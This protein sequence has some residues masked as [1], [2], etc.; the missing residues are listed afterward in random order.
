[1]SS[2]ISGSMQTMYNSVSTWM[3]RMASNI[4]QQAKRIQSA[5]NSVNTA[6]GSIQ[7]R[8]VTV[9]AHAKGGQIEDGL[10]MANSGEIIGEFSN[11]KNYV[12]NNEM[13]VEGIEQGVF[14]AV[15]NAIMNNP[16]QG[17]GGDVVLMI[18]SEEIARASIKGQRSIDRRFNP[19]VKFTG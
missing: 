12:A 13:I 4:E 2:S 17:A 7:S 14:N 11:G 5:F 9:P 10:F 16:N 18:D 1:M 19:V 8:T 3:A 6:A 15:S